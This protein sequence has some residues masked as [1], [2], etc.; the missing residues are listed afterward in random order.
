[1]I[2]RRF[3]D[4]GLDDTGPDDTGP[5]GDRL[6][7]AQVRRL[8]A[9]YHD[10]EGEPQLYDRINAHL[11]ACAACSGWY[12][13][14]RRFDR[15]IEDHLRPP[16]A[17]PLLWGRL[18]VGAG[19]V[20]PSGNHRGCL[21][22]LVVAA[23]GLLV[24]LL[25]SLRPA[26]DL[27]A[28]VLHWHT[29]L[30]QGAE[31]PQ[32]AS[33]SD[34]VVEDYLRGRV[35][36]P[37][38]CPPRQDSGFHV[39]GAGVRRKA[40]GEVAYLTGRIGDSPVSIFI[41]PQ[42]VRFPASDWET[43]D[44]PAFRY[45]RRRG[46]DLMLRRFD[47]NWV[48]VVGRTDRGRLSRVLRAYGSYHD[49]HAAPR[50]NA[51]DG[52]AAEV[53]SVAFRPGDDD[54]TADSDDEQPPRAPSDVIAAL[55]LGGCG[56][57][58][59]IA[60]VPGADGQVGPDLSDIG[61]VAGQRRDGY[62]A[63]EYLR[64]SITAPDA[65]IA[66]D[67]T[68]DEYPAGVMLQ[69]FAESLSGNDIEAIVDYL[70]GLGVD[71]PGD[72]PTR[73]VKLSRQAPPES[74]L[75]PPAEL[76]QVADEVEKIALGRYLFFDRRLSAN[77]SLACATCHR[78]EHA[79]SDGQQLSRGYPSTKL[80]RNTPSLVN[81]GYRSDY[82]WDGR[83]GDLPSVVRDHITEAHFMAMDGRLMVQRLIQVP[84]YAELFQEI[85]GDEPSFGKVLDA[86]AAYVASLNSASTP[87]DRFLDGDRDALSEEATA[88]LALFRGKAGCARC[89]QGPLLS[90]GSFHH[91]D[92]PAVGD[93][94]DDPRREVTFR[95][96]FR[97]L[98]VPAY[99]H[100]DGDPGRYAVTLDEDDRG[101]FRT[102][103][104]R[105]VAHTA[106]YM[107]NGSLKTLRQ[108]ARFYNAGGG[109]GQSADL[110]PLG[111]SERQV[112]QLVA[113]LQALGN[114][115]IELDPP[116]L[117]DYDVFPLG[118]GNDQD[119]SAKDRPSSSADGSSERRPAAELADHFPLLAPL[120]DPPHPPD[121]PISDAKAEL[122]KLLYFDPRMS[123]DGS[124]SCHSCHATSTGWTLR[125][126]ISMGSPGSSHW[127]NSQTVLNVA[128]YSKFNWDGA[129]S[130]IEQ[131]NAGAWTGAVAGNLDPALAE[132]RLTQI[133]QYVERFAEVFGTELPSWDD[134]L[135]AVATFQRQIVSRQVP[136]DDYLSG[137]TTAISEAAKRGHQLFV[138]KAR[139]IV[140][141]H[142]PL[143]GDD[144]YHALGVP[145]NEDFLDS[146]L[147]QIT[148][149]FQLASKGVPRQRYRDSDRDEGLY[150][151]TR[152]D[153][154]RG[155]FRTPT[156]RDLIHTAPYMHNGVFQTLAE[157]V[158]FYDAGGGDG[159]N[160]SPLVEPL[161]LS[162]AERHDLVAFLQSLSGD[163]IRI[164]AP[165]LP[166]YRSRQ[167]QQ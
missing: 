60:G 165:Q 5:D 122:G 75:Q 13:S 107:H 56:G 81:A 73:Q 145:P 11:A 124:T 138:G 80:F 12:E 88:G 15:R 43:L 9:L 28:S 27:A 162:E 70:A 148:F 156:L 63:R 72:S 30:V 157:V 158:E 53:R 87:Y 21:A 32:L 137:D 24:A 134:A 61:A 143:A 18:L 109:P 14:Q 33:D 117:P 31:A 108:V 147:K 57:C 4:D 16:P 79:F 106:P 155:K 116:E 151:V 40:G 10:G 91:L 51:R 110:Q 78:P 76:P 54:Q 104:L 102:P 85:Y 118:N 105:E 159:P 111:L 65:F 90:D 161:G 50:S 112:D 103:S 98:G 74:V 101:K 44:D 119:A 131:Q 100:L 64:E 113:F 19:L 83:I 149:R 128:W 68:E 45:G 130:S 163:P 140:C 127:R 58:H 82:F 6:D 59:R 22:L 66:P 94:L 39:T 20:R 25:W 67:G 36:F 164:A 52:A 120:G 153:E 152:R 132:E 1:M 142:G 35:S 160:K 17:D 123:G 121:N 8:R 49:Q 167:E 144:D 125:T 37:V 166:E 47:R 23:A 99:R 84:A 154:D 7:C 95:R 141:H 129:A 97:V 89:H 126:A 133:P 139:C 77:N 62:S 41:F 136:F 135:R 69:S 42:S 86:L 115:P 93:L 3:D 150:Y 71:Q 34:R 146:P 2:A 55:N 114:E 29:R 96:F 38:R 48:L 46:Y 92:V 26:T